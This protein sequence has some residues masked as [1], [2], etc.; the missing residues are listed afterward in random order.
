[1]KSTIATYILLLLFIQTTTAQ[2]LE[3][4]FRELKQT[5]SAKGGE[6]KC[7]D[8]KGRY[9]DFKMAWGNAVTRIIQPIPNGEYY[10]IKTPI[11]E[12]WLAFGA[13]KGFLGYPANSTSYIKEA[14]CFNNFV[15]Q[16]ASIYYKPATGAHIVQGLIY[17]HWVATG[18]L[19]VYGYPTTDE[20]FAKDANLYASQFEKGVISWSGANGITAVTGADFTNWNKSGGALGRLG[21]PKKREANGAIT[22]ERLSKETFAQKPLPVTLPAFDLKALATIAAKEKIAPKAVSL[23][24]LLDF[25]VTAAEFTSEVIGVSNGNIVKFKEA[26]AKPY[27]KGWLVQSSLGTYFLKTQLYE[28]WKENQ[29][30]SGSLGFPWSNFGYSDH[31]G[32]YCDFYNLETKEFTRLYGGPSTSC[33]EVGAFGNELRDC[34]NTSVGH[35]LR[36]HDNTPNG[37]VW[38]CSNGSVCENFY[39]GVLRTFNDFNGDYLKER[40][41]VRGYVYPGNNTPVKSVKISNGYAEVTLPNISTLPGN[42]DCGSCSWY[43]G[44]RPLNAPEDTQFWK[45]QNNTFRFAVQSKTIYRFFAQSAR[46]NIEIFFLTR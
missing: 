20:I 36:Y 15:G 26:S 16:N 31:N 22:Y 23:K 18:G 29:M 11:L 10:L 1:M 2:S 19:E 24:P 42:G 43:V 38:Q 45:S 30:G 46:A 7:D 27:T 28:Y 25:V 9:K 4:K 32:Y 40:Y 34:F 14:G 6:V 35:P 5:G 17:K 21:W 3:Q 33:F 44:I 39:T 12:K 13:E 41:C 8:G 37:R